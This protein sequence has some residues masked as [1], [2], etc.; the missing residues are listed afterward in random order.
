MNIVNEIINGVNLKADVSKNI[1]KLPIEYIEKKIILSD[2]IKSDLELNYIEDVS[3]N[4]NDISINCL[5]NNIFNF[6]SNVEKN[7]ISKYNKY[8]TNDK[9]FLLDTQILLKNYTITESIDN[10]DSIDTTIN[11]ITDDLNFISKYQYI[12]LPYLYRFNNESSILLINSI[13][14]LINPVIALITPIIMLFIPFILIKI[15]G[16]KVTIDDY[17][18]ILKEVLS[19]HIFGKLLFQFGSTS[20]SNRV[21]ILVSFGFYL[22]Q[23]Y[24]NINN[25]IKFNRYVYEINSKLYSIKE[26]LNKSLNNFKNLLRHTQNLSTYKMFNDDLQIKIDYLTRYYN[27]L[28]IIKNK[29]FS[30]AVDIK[31]LGVILKQFYQL[32]NNK[33]LIDTIY[34]TVGLNS[35]ISSLTSIKT[36]LD[37]GSINYC[38]YIDNKDK[39]NTYLKNQYYAPLLK[40]NDK[41]VR[42]NIKLD[43]NIIISGPNASGK[44]TILK[45]CFYNIILSQQIGC[46]FYESANIKIYDMLHCYINIPDTSNRDSL[47]QAEARRCKDILTTIID[48]KEKNHFCIFDELYSGTNPDEAVKSAYYLLDNICKYNKVDFML[49]THYIKLCKKIKTNNEKQDIKK[50]IN[51]KMDSSLD[52]DNNLIYNYRLTKGIS[53]IKGGINVLKNME[54]PKE[55]IDKINIDKDI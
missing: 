40:Y 4:T 21:Y 18:S 7:I 49:T 26:Y 54:Y 31:N 10:I 12:D 17:V 37:N 20:I 23:M 32:Y 9:E 41:I 19:K 38:N 22:F 45:S 29:S 3:I 42:N 46:G 15:W 24:L 44:T 34:Y 13:N 25:C 2:I 27:D 1:F 14:N 55:I 51:Y 5:Y 47:F 6:S 50:I 43:N 11:T 36:N 28:Y 35:Y 39:G 48:N 52:N 33:T 30:Y 16:R 8:Y 53:K